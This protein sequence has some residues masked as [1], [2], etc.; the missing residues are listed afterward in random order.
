MVV[1]DTP[2]QSL[3]LAAA[4]LRSAIIN[5][6]NTAGDLA[7]ATTGLRGRLGAAAAAILCLAGAFHG[8]RL[9][10]PALFAVGAVVGGWIVYVGLHAILMG[11]PLQMPVAL[12]GAAAAAA[13]V[14][15]A[16]MELL[17]VGVFLGGVVAGAVAGLALEGPLGALL[18]LPHTELL[19]AI[20]G[21]VGGAA[22]LYGGRARAEIVAIAL[23]YAGAAGAAV[24]AEVAVT[25][26]TKGPPR[27]NGLLGLIWWLVVGAV[28][29]I[30]AVMQL[31]GGWA[32][33]HE[34]DY[35][36]IE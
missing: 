1:L 35:V 7:V 6:G 13:G 30:A 4:T 9:L 25:G 36:E 20:G 19:V 5:D 28:G 26:F 34:A 22:A 27:A 8:A 29:T 31:K 32:R 23:A 12:I 33:S 24:A 17:P 21:V 11:L 18:G 14:G 16:S 2:P 3:L 10:R 15:I